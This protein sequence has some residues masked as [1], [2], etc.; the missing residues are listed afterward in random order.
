MNRPVIPDHIQALKPYVAGRS[1]E[2]IRE[3]LGLERIIKLASNENPLGASPKAVEAVRAAASSV[4]VY[5]RAGLRLRE[6][7][8]QRLDVTP[9]NVAVASGSEGVMLHAMR[10]YLQP[11][12]EVVTAEGT[13]IGFYVIAHAMKLDLKTV[14]LSN[15]TY[16]LE[17]ILAAVTDRTRLIYLANPNNPTGT[18]YTSDE[19]DAF[20]KKLPENILVICDEAYFEYAS[21]WKAYPNSLDW[22][23]D[24]VLTLRTF[25]KAYGLAGARIGYGLAH[26]EIIGTILKVK[27]PFEPTALAEAAG[28]GALNDK[29]FLERTL[30]TN[31]YGMRRLTQMLD[32]HGVQYPRS[33]ANFLLIPRETPEH[34]QA[35][36]DKLLEAGIIARPMVPFRL[37]HCV[38]VTIGSDSE[39][40]ILLDSMPAAL[41]V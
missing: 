1:I 28:L 16:D 26:D 30:E 36:S 8:A 32:R 24:Q 31:R 9:A 19:W 29:D 10:G 11:G 34:A 41:S 35:M 20:L 17:A 27:L 18:A 12:D 40:D 25:S 2:E 22:R 33:V 39:M 21:D 37:P 5:P 14:P 7:L 13:F 15:Y 23:H 3:T 4:N 38:R 6:K